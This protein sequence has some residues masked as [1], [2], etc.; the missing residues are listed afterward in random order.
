MNLQHTLLTDHS[1]ST[2]TRIVRWIGNHP[3]RFD[4]LMRLFLSADERL[5][6]CAAWPLGYAAIAHPVLLKKHFSSLVRQLRLPDR[7]DAIKRNTLRILESVPIPVRF[8]GQVMDDCFRFINDPQEKPAVKAYS[9]TVLEQLC[10]V[11]PDI[12]PEL[13]SVI[14]HRWPTE[15]AAFRSRARKIS[16]RLSR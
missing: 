7:H 3:E 2:V 6:Q 14:Q 8:H 9:L 16:K 11:Y 4:A 5:A 1:K 12:A 13:L 10:G 15:S